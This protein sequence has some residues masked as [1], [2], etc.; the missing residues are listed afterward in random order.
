[1]PSVTLKKP[2][3]AATTEEKQKI[4]KFFRGMKGEVIFSKKVNKAKANLKK[5]KLI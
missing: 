4:V 5:A 2:E 3:I 1:M